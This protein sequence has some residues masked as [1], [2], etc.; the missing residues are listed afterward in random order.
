MEEAGGGQAVRVLVV[1]SNPGA[2]QDLMSDLRR[3]SYT[4]FTV[5]TGEEA[6]KSHCCADLILLD[7]DLPDLDGLELCRGI[8][9]MRDIPIIAVTG[10]GSELDLVLGLKSGADDYVVKPY[11]KAELLARMEALLRRALPKEEPKS[12]IAHG[13]LE[14]DAQAREVRLGG[15]P[16]DVTRKEF[17]LLFV[18]ASK[19]GTVLSRRELL[20]EVW[21]DTWSHRGRTIDTHVSSLRGKLGEGWIVTVRG[22]GFRFGHS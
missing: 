11:R 4:A 13:P 18:L 10:R 12:V 7:L 17:D 20:A 16:V 19:P 3:H 1:E 14:L 8:R 2:A 5:P 22:I 6:L 9:A 15:Q 21:N